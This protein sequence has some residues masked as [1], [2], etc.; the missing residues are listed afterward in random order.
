MYCKDLSI[1]DY[2]K[3]YYKLDVNAS[4]ITIKDNQNN[5]IF[6]R[7]PSNDNWYDDKHRAIVHAIHTLEALVLEIDDNTKP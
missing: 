3:R 4:W 5:I 1:S 2:D 7:N 6:S